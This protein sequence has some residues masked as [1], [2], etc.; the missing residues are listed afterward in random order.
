MT[1]SPALGAVNRVSQRVCIVD[2]DESVR[3]SVKRLLRSINVSAAT[4]ASASDFLASAA[5]NAF[6]CAIFD[7]RMPGM[8]GLS[9]QECLCARGSRMAVI[10]ITAHNE[11]SIRERAL[12]NGAAGFFFKPLLGKELLDAVCA[13]LESTTGTPDAVRTDRRK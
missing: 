3:I 5:D 11:E 6:E 12:K 2:D 4:F 10:F 9:L 13:A 1:P 8:D 7:V